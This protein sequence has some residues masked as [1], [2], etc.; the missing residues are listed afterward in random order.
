MLFFYLFILLIVGFPIAYIL[1]LIPLKIQANAAGVPCPLSQLI[2]M[3]LRK[4][5][6][7]DVVEARI[8]L[9]KAGIAVTYNDLESHI[10]AGGFLYQVTEACI[11]AVKAGLEVD[12]NQICAIDLAGRDVLT[13]VESSVNPIIVEVPAKSTGKRYIT[14][15]AK[16]GIRLGVNVKVT[17]RADIKKLVGGAT[18]ET[19]RARVGEGIVATIGSVDDHR[20]ILENPK[21]ISQRILKKGL[22]ANTAFHIVSVDVG[23]IDIQDNIG[24]HIQE[25]QAE[26][27]KLV[28]QA[29]AEARKMQANAQYQ[30]NIAK[31]KEM[32]AEERKNQAKVPT[33]MATAFSKGQ[34]AISRKPVY[35][36]IDRKLW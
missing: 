8:T 23:D 4:I 25:V 20:H 9:Q 3:K 33:Q 35:S 29:K 1:Q 6:P 31:T 14:G 21:L 36:V 11:S 7:K 13:A 26:A 28:A 5:N 22:D 27:D 30:E 17:V 24:A 16:D 19:I 18:E 12:F 34:I 15:V 10:L 32:S 2:G